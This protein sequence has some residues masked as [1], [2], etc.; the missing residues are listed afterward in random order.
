MGFRTCYLPK[1]GTLAFEEIAKVKGLSDLMPF[2]L[3]VGHR[4]ES[5]QTVLAK[6]LPVYNC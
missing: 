4:A 2:S 6:F 3:E 1:H 5:E